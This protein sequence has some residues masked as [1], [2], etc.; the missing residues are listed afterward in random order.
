MIV[1]SF[2]TVVPIDATPP[3]LTSTTT[4]HSIVKLIQF[5]IVTETL[6][7]SPTSEPITSPRT[8][9]AAPTSA[10][11]T[12]MGTTSTI[13]RTLYLVKPVRTVTHY[14][15]RQSAGGNT[16]SVPTRVSKLPAT[17][18]IPSDTVVLAD[19]STVD[20]FRTFHTKISLPEMMVKS[21][22]MNNSGPKGATTVD[23]GIG[24]PSRNLPLRFPTVSTASLAPSSLS[25]SNVE[26]SG[27]STADVMISPKI[28]VVDFSPFISHG[29]VHTSTAPPAF[30]TLIYPTTISLTSQYLSTRR[31]WN[32]T[33]RGITSGV[34]P[35]STLATPTP[36]TLQCG[37]KGNFTLNVSYFPIP[38][39]S[40]LT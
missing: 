28:S 11:V 36:N 16:E 2:V 29:T 30:S 35:T 7:V 38:P 9:Q 33:S 34:A 40:R 8:E 25:A 37:E 20:I 22:F 12:V 3:T 26:N 13:T 14:P 24:K 1:T 19:D 31:H 39:S 15:G 5:F 27:T 23:I 21:G 18:A 10:N 32:T 4:L 17:T 6:D